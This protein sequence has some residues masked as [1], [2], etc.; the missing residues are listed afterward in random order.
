GGIVEIGPTEKLISE[1]KHPYTRLLL[2]ASPEPDPDLIKPPVEEAGEIP[3]AIDVPNGCRF[4]TRCPVATPP[5]G[6]EGRDVA[7][8]LAAHA[9]EH[10]QPATLGDGKIQD[11]DIEFEAP[12][13]AKVALPDL[14]AI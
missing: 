5:C 6:W 11:L 10:A 14:R 9:I 8:A 7:S 3:S 13:G 4:H 1:R 12:Q 2:D